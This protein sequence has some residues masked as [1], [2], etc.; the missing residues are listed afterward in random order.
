MTTLSSVCDI[1]DCEHR[2][3]PTVPNGYPLIRTPDIDVGRLRVE[4]A[5]RVDEATYQAWTKRAVPQEG[6]LILAREAPVGNVGII[7]PGVHPVL[8]QRTVLIRPRREVLD[9]YYLNYLLSGP[10]LRGWMNGVSIGAT[11]PHLNVADIRSMELPV[12]PPLPT[13]R[14]IAA[15][16]CAYDDLIENND[17][18]I[19]LLDAIAERTYRE[20]F[21]YLRYPGHG[22]DSL[23]HSELARV[24]DGWFIRN[25]GAF[26]TVVL[27]GTPSRKVARYWENGTVPWINSGRVNQLRVIEPSELISEEALASSSAKLMPKGTTLLAITGATLGQ[28]SMLEIAACANQSVVGVYDPSD[29]HTEFLYLSIRHS[30]K[31]IIGAASGGAQQHIN[32]QVVRETDIRIPTPELADRFRAIVRPIFEAIAFLLRTQLCLNASRELLL[33]RLVSGE[34]DVAELNIRLSQPTL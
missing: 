33:P 32:Q 10:E 11:V 14:K 5:Q 30:I 26:F 23:S 27:G 18:R 22:D 15:I 20:W 16:L 7:R 25:L 21:V 2:T 29:R 24:P 6:E 13:Q 1:V 4:S 28:V 8:G 17:R 3:A 19:E 31:R 12:L 34:I 9:P